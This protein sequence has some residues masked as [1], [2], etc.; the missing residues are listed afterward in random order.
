LV[1]SSPF[2]K[3]HQWSE[4][5]Q[6]VITMSTLEELVALIRTHI[7]ENDLHEV[8]GQLIA[9]E[10]RK[11]MFQSLPTDVSTEIWDY[12]IIEDDG[13]NSCI[14]LIG[15]MIDFLPDTVTMR[16]SKNWTPIHY[17]LFKPNVPYAGRKH[18]D[19]HDVLPIDMRRKLMKL[20]RD[21]I[22][23]RMGGGKDDGDYMLHYA[24]Q[25]MRQHR[26]ASGTVRLL[27][28]EYPEAASLQNGQGRTP[29]HLLFCNAH[30]ERAGVGYLN[31]STTAIF[32]LLLSQHPAAAKVADVNGNLPIH[33]I[34]IYHRINDD[35]EVDHF[36]KKLVDAF[37]DSTTMKGSA[38]LTP[39]AL[40]CREVSF[41]VTTESALFHLVKKCPQDVLHRDRFGRLPFHY[42][43][44]TFNEGG[45]D[46]VHIALDV[47]FGDDGESEDA[48]SEDSKS[49]DNECVGGEYKAAKK[50]K[51]G[52]S[53]R[54]NTS[55]VKSD[56][57]QVF[58]SLVD[59]ERN[60]ILHS[61]VGQKNTKYYLTHEHQ[62][63][64]GILMTKF[65]N[66]L[67]QL[68]A[69]R[70][71]LGQLPLHL[72]IRSRLSVGKYEDII[73]LVERYPEAALVRDPRTGLYPFMLA[74]VDSKTRDNFS[75]T[76]FLLQILLGFQSLETL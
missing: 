60:N 13:E 61:L 55:G 72:R 68:A 49:K 7:R 29:L 74:A 65:A 62:R 43:K 70:N 58:L 9:S 64:N 15:Y 34:M 45:Y 38:G 59:K 18:S 30:D 40:V 71:M 53:R 12:I 69:R 11:K 20:G 66:W 46:D 32:D 73:M 54:G 36:T 39:L 52:E 23:D 41:D 24:I 26:V 4:I 3:Y 21:V 76:F 44:S 2:D 6:L 14:D 8:A 28:D 5:P 51:D 48:D 50:S 25:L 17:L 19:F 57:K 31:P 35:K 47:M 67:P 16:D 37:P 56:L 27:F 33:L 42:L 1:L 10:E 75:A 63:M 22:R